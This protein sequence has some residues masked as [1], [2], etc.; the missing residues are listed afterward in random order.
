M[1]I[2]ACSTPT[3]ELAVEGPPV[4]TAAEMD[5]LLAGAS[6][7]DSLAPPTIV[8]AVDT[9]AA[10]SLTLRDIG[11]RDGITLQGATDQAIVAVPVN[12]G[13]QPVRLVVAVTPT[14]LMPSATIYLQQG[15]RV[16]AQ[17]ALTDTTSQVVF[18]LTEAITDG[19]RAP[20]T[21]G[22]NIPGRDACAADLLYRTVVHPTSRVE[23]AGARVPTG[24]MNDFFQPWVKRVVFYLPESPSLDAAQAA[25]DAAAFVGRA[26]RGMTT[27]FAILPL[28]PA[29]TP[30]PEPAP[31]ERALLW[32]PS[33]PTMV[34]RPE[35]GAGRVLALAS[36]RDARQLFTLAEGSRLVATDGFRATTV[37]P[38]LVLPVRS[39]AITFAQL[40]L[41]PR[42]A[43]GSAIVSHSIPFALADFGHY[44]TPYA[45]RL[46][47][48]H[49][50]LPREGHGTMNVYL[51][52]Q[53]IESRPV[54]RPDLD[55]TVSLPGHLLQRDNRLDVRFNVVLGQGGCA[56]GGPTFIATLD[57]RSTFLLTNGSALAPSF[58]RF[59]SAFVPAFSVLMEPRDRFRVDLAA[60]AIGAMQQTTVTPLAPFVVRDLAEVRGAL[61]AI[62][63]GGMATA[64]DAPLSGD[65]FRMRDTQGR[66]WDEFA[67]TQ[68]FASMQSFTHD[69]R[70][71]LLLHHTRDDGAPLDALL[72]DALAPYG[73]FGVHGDL[74]LRG[75]SGPTTVLNL[76]NSGWVIERPVGAPESLFARYRSAIFLGAGILLLALAIWLYPR[77]VRREL[78]TTG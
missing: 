31:D 60:R 56:L 6:V 33:G 38:E 68:S 13:L 11:F 26:Y 17:H 49:S 1:A 8:P 78:D 27:E 43:E 66:V 53:L 67:P 4:P 76:A 69:G 45:A 2:A 61:L 51:N 29:G 5:S 55:L 42:T 58:D 52:G 25:L 50:A 9:L 30:I 41:P 20:I 40:D 54:E 7:D 16:L 10:M 59:P 47:L 23:Y 72:R 36:R 48:R 70:D 39:G 12:R 62:G 14:P 77:V 3:P 65:G 37:R 28:P 71:I 18:S 44:V 74:A 22:V 34:L 57:D 21:L 15:P 35:G 46:I 75:P 19:G 73:W 64:L 63:T 24:G 32:V